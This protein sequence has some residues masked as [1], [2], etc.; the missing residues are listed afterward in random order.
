MWAAVFAT[1]PATVILNC[2]NSTKSF[3]VDAGVSK[4]SI[5]LAPGKMIVKMIRTGQ[6]IIDYT[7]DGYRFITNPIM[8]KCSTVCLFFDCKKPMHDH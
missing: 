5:P 3:N 8:C 2:G 1:A 4:L 6:K 7:P